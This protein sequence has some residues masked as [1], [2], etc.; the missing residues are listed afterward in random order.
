VQFEG[1]LDGSTYV[2]ILGTPSTGGAAVSSATANG[3]WTFSGAYTLVQVRASAAM[4]GTLTPTLVFTTSTAGGSFIPPLL[5]PDGT[6]G[7]PT[8]A[9]GSSSGSGLWWDGSGIA[10]STTGTKRGVH[11]ATTFTLLADTGRL[12]MGASADWSLG[13]GGAGGSIAFSGG[14]TPTQSGTTCGTGPTIVGNNSSGS[15]TLGTSPGLPCTIVFSGTWTSAPRCW[16]NPDI[17]TTATTTVRATGITTGQ[18]V[19][20]TSA[21]LVATDK[22][23]WHCESS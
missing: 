10:W 11:G 1:T 23:S 6:A 22:I 7:A 13:R 15:V 4:T 19:I 21:A 2:S 16:L 14:T 20:T 17:L 3:T 8:Y 9:F 18:F 12:I 5:G